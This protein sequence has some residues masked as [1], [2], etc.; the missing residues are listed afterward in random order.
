LHLLVEFRF[1]ELS[2]GLYFKMLLN[3]GLVMVTNTCEATITKRL[4]C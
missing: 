3:Q 1:D 2:Y 4:E